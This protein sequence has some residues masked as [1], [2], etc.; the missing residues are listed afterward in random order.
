M[1]ILTCIIAAEEDEV[2]AIGESLQ[3][4]DEWSGITFRDL[5]IPRIATLH[6][7]LTG[8]LYDDACAHYEP[9]YVSAAE[10][11]MVLRVAVS[12]CE[13][14]VALDEAALEAVTAELAAT[15]DFEDAG[16]DDEEVAEML[17]GLVDLACLAESQGQVLFVWMHP[18]RT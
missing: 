13:R 9:V 16:W 12:A 7:I 15:E 1:A 10:G 17:T 18:L 2:E 6:C 11:A 14:L 4:V 8:D 3:P 5:T